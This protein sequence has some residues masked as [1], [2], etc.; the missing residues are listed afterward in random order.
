MNSA[1]FA[2]FVRTEIAK[3]GRVIKD[4]NIHAQ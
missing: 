1:Q 2:G 4:G 3:W